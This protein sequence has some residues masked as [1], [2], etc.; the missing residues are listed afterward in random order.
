VPPLAYDDH[1]VTLAWP[2]PPGAAGIVDCRV[3]Q[4]GV[5]V[6]TANQGAAGAAAESIRRFHADPAN[7]RQVR[8]ATTG[9]ATRTP[10]PS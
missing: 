8:I 2:A 7:D 4:D 3:H 9:G 5:P 1:S 10:P 6:G